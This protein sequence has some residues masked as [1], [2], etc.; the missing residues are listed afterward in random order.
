MPM[1]AAL[2]RHLPLLLLVAVLGAVWWRTGAPPLRAAGPWAPVG[3]AVLLLGLFVR[4]LAPSVGAPRWV[5]VA[6]GGA[7]AVGLGLWLVVVGRAATSGPQ[8]GG[9][10]LALAALAGYAG[11][12]WWQGRRSATAR[13]AVPG[14]PG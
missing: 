10:R 7:A 4:L 12:G 13:E 3:L 14:T 11:W 6:G 9:T 8:A 2:R 5:G 1:S